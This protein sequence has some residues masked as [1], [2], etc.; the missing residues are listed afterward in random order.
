MSNEN[1]KNKNIDKDLPSPYCDTCG[2]C[3][4]DGCCP[5]TKCTQ[6]N[7]KYCEYYLKLLKAVY[8]AYTEI[9]SDMPAETQNKFTDI[10]FKEISEQ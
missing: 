1:S 4:E 7:G 5:P 10:I 6:D 9:Y 3:G 8:K 2:A